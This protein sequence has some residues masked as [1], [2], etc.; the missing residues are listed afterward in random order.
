MPS[1]TPEPYE[2]SLP[3]AGSADGGSPSGDSIALRFGLAKRWYASITDASTLPPSPKAREIDG[4]ITV[5]SMP[6]RPSS[7][8][9]RT[10]PLPSAYGVSLAKARLT[11]SEIPPSVAGAASNLSSGMRIVRAGRSVSITLGRTDSAAGRLAHW[12][13]GVIPRSA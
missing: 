4:A 11:P 10:S 6:E 5:R 9:A 13:S 2:V 1:R 12:Y 7:I 3:E 8:S